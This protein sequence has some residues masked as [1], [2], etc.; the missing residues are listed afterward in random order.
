MPANEVIKFSIIADEK[1]SAKFNKVF[2]SLSGGVNVA[3]QAGKAITAAGVAIVGFTTVVANGIDKQAKFATRLKESV[4]TLT[5][6]QFAA[7]QAGIGTD[8]FNMAVQRMERRVSEAAKG[9]GEAKGALEEM[10]IKARDFTHLPLDEKLAVLADKTAQYT[11]EKDRLR[12]AMK[13]FDSEGVSMLQLLDQGG[14]AMRA[15]A[16]DA[17]FLG[18]A[19]SKQAAAQAELFSDKM[20]RAKAAIQGASNTIAGEFMP[21][22]AGMAD[23]FA[24]FLASNR[25]N[26]ANFVKG[27]IQGFF[28]VTLAVDDMGKHVRKTFTQFDAF[29]SFLSALGQ[30]VVKTAKRALDVGK[31]IATGVKEGLAAALSVLNAFGDYAADRLRAI[32]TKEKVKPIGEAFSDILS[33]GFE[34]ATNNLKTTWSTVGKELISNAADTGE[35]LAETLGVNLDNI[36]ER[37]Q[38]AIGDLGLFAEATA[39]NVENS[40]ERISEFLEAIR[41]KKSEFFTWINDS[42][43]QFSENLFNTM[44]TGI[45]NLSSGLAEAIM[46]GASMMDVLKNVA[47]QTLAAVLAAL[48]KMGIQRLILSVKNTALSTKEASVDAAKGVGLAGVNMFASMAAAPFPINLTA[49]AAASA[50]IAGASAAFTAGAAIGTGLGAGVGAVAHGGLTNNPDEQTVL[51]R[52]GERIVSPRQNQDLTQFLET[53]G[54][55]FTIGTMQ[56]TMFPNATNADAVFDMPVNEMAGKMEDVIITALNN[57]SRKGVKPDFVEGR[58]S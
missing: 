48:I 51:V 39:E 45:D 34:R 26:I 21:I 12:V 22:L 40:T 58:A 53:G 41:E 19:I 9:L 42:Y 8:A 25:A 30:L 20:G 16:E 43:T 4:E 33:E 37:A 57:A 1:A 49:P 56:I 2:K 17:K 32:F 13:L 47:K 15:A 27:A 38:S 18:V 6:Y 29:N 7:N 23:Q 5:A 55:G 10:G 54:A 11:N 31:A 52:R 3:K 14:E 24:T 28:M 35:D 46:T 44:Q 36:G 50:A